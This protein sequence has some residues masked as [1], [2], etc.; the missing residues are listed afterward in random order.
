MKDRGCDEA[1][2]KRIISALACHACYRI[3]SVY[4]ML[5]SRKK[6]NRGARVL[7]PLVSC[8]FLLRT[9]ARVFSYE[10]AQT[11]D[12]DAEHVLPRICH[13]VSAERIPHAEDLDEEEVDV[14]RKRKRKDA[15]AHA[16]TYG[17]TQ[18]ESRVTTRIRLGSHTQAVGVR[19]HA[20]TLCRG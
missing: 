13:A 19:P 14:G 10:P 11:T 2:L 17:C 12:G 8:P 5:Y 18:H 6:G 20:H 15:V 7:H 3:C 16:S 4:G 9:R 1:S